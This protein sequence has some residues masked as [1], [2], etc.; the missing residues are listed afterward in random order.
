MTMACAWWSKVA[1]TECEM[2]YDLR[3]WSN[4]TDI[5][6]EMLHDSI[7]Q[8]PPHCPPKSPRVS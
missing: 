7:S 5:E 8:Q 2:L 3:M 4:V 6:C 1:D